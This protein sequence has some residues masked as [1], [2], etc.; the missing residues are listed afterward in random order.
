MLAVT[1]DIVI[2]SGV[3]KKHIR[4]TPNS[5]TSWFSQL[6]FQIIKAPAMMGRQL[7]IVTYIRVFR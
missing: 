3:P 2:A 4:Y 5:G 6:D 1:R 7:K